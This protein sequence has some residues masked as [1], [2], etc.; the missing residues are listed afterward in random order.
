[1]KIYSAHLKP[2]LPPLQGLQTG[3]VCD[4]IVIPNG[5]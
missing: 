5:K 3:G 4:A 2:I 1:M